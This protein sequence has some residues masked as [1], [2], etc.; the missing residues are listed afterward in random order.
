MRGEFRV[1]PRQAI[2]AESV[3]G[4][5]VPAG[6]QDED[7]PAAAGSG[8]VAATAT[9]PATWVAFRMVDSLGDPARGVKYEVTLPDGSTQQDTLDDNGLAK[10][11]SPQSGSCKIS[12]PDLDA[13]DWDRA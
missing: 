7:E 2:T 12:F 10:V 8:A 1:V 9:S 4:G 5:A 3:F 11:P 13:G 6:T